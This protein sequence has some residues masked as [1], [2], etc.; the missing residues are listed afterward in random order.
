MTAPATATPS[1][2]GRPRKQLADQL[3]RMDTIIDAL[4]EA[5]PEAVADATREG[6]RL[7]V[8]DVILELLANPDLRAVLGG[9]APP[10]ASDPAPPSCEPTAAAPGLWARL[11][12]RV[13]AARDA[14]VARWRTAAAP[15][16]VAVR[17]LAVVVPLRRVAAVAAGVGVAAGLAA[18]ACPHAVAAAAAGVCG[19]A[20][21][22]AAQVGHW[23]RRSAG[24]FRPGVTT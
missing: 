12:A 23:V 22:V 14:A 19:A 10:P 6:A 1:A 15:V 17:A 7:A 18:Y 13:A 2:N 21:A 5:L 3:D 16:A 20:A 11:K 9:L 24:V 8:K 4:A